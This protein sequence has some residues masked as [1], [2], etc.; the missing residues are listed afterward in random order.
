MYIHGL[1]EKKLLA[2]LLKIMFKLV[3]NVIKEVA[4]ESS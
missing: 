3:Y 1:S 4:S 2:N